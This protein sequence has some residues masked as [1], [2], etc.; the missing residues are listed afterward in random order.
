VNNTG[1]EEGVAS[2]N[3]GADRPYHIAS[4]PRVVKTALS[5]SPVYLL[6]C[7]NTDKATTQAEIEAAAR[8]TIKWLQTQN[9]AVALE[10]KVCPCRVTHRYI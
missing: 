3:A 8:A 9:N 2:T 1:L 10:P 6:Y 4:L 7:Y 5:A